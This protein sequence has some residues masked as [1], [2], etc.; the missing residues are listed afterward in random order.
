VRRYLLP[1]AVV[2]TLLGLWEVLAQTGW[3]ADLL[4]INEAASDLLVPPPTQ[5][6]EALWE[7]RELLAE[8]GWATLLELLAGVG[9]SL[10]LGAGF[11][12]AMHLSE[13]LRRAFYPLLIASQTIPI[14][15]IAPVLY[16]WLDFGV[17]P[18]LAV[19][20]LICFFPVTVNTLD[21][22]RS[23]DID[24]I[25]M[26]RTLDAGRAA[27]LRRLELPAAL[28]RF[29]SGAKVAVAV[30]AI[31]AVFGEY[32]SANEGLGV[33]IKEAQAQLLTAR[34]FAAIVVL[35]AFALALFGLLTTLERRYAWWGEKG[36]S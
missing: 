36:I 20:V 12:V 6:A 31:G 34:V 13:T 35:S 15:A 5:V 26:M 7:D 11:A 9:L 16:I 2:L 27:I 21:G 23:V 1:A 8:N 22:L 32:V 17:G 24:A 30:A 19:I 29:F 18:T 10:I 14:V 4:G 33:V 25:R 3:L 28:P